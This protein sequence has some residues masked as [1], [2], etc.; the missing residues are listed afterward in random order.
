M[1]N[2]EFKCVTIVNHSRKP[3]KTTV[4][5]FN[6]EYEVNLV[7]DLIT[8]ERFPV[9]RQ[10]SW[11]EFDCDVEDLSGRFIGLYEK[12]PET[13]EIEGRDSY[14]KGEFLYLK[15][16]PESGG[17]IV[18]GEFLARIVCKDPEGDIESDKIISINSDGYIIGRPISINEI[19]G[20]WDLDIEILHSGALK[21]FSWLVR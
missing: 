15:I 14:E 16:L 5:V 1:S 20:K 2:N 12:F 18:K 4:C 17:N 8:Y 3:E 11:I 6:P 9:R 7:V 13:I 19:T 21:K 10:E